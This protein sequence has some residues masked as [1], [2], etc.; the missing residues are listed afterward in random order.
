MH[1]SQ[2]HPSKQATTSVLLTLRRYGR[3]QQVIVILELLISGFFFRL[4]YFRIRNI[5]R[6][7]VV[8]NDINILLYISLFF[9]IAHAVSRPSASASQADP[10]GSALRERRG[11]A[12]IVKG[13]TGSDPRSRSRASSEIVTFERFDAPRF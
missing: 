10:A 5:C 3:Q 13:R 1:V 11:R 8:Y 12:V 6:K 2:T 4:S 7:N 9:F